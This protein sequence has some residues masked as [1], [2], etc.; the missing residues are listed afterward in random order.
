MRYKG[1]KGKAWEAVKR[2]IRSREVDCYTCYRKDLIA[3]QLKADA[4]HYKPVALVGSNNKL[5]WLPEFIHLQC[6]TCNGSGQGM[7]IEYR[8]HLEKEYGKEKVQWFEDNYRKTNPVK[9]WQ[10][11]INTFNALNKQLT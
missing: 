11:V 6:A 4:G 3:S 8:V 2:S 5:S 7:A 10:E 1:V 9:D